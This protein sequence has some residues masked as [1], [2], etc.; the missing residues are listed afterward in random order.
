MKPVARLIHPFNN[1]VCT[2]TRVIRTERQTGKK[3]DWWFRR[4]SLPARPVPAA[5]SRRPRVALGIYIHRQVWLYA[6]TGR[7]PAN[8]AS[9]EEDI[10]IGNGE[11]WSRNGIGKSSRHSILRR[12][13]ESAVHKP[14]EVIAWLLFPE[15]SISIKLRPRNEFAQPW[16]RPPSAGAIVLA[17]VSFEFPWTCTPDRGLIASRSIP[18]PSE[19]SL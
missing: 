3:R 17:R 6:T 12:L 1:H 15:A 2:T 5:L 4:K 13:G 11:R 7:L 19:R 18:L 9:L 16:S 8:G 10:G 14:L